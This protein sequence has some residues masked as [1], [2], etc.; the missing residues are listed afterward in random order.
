MRTWTKSY[1]H[2]LKKAAA[3]IPVCLFIGPAWRDIRDELLALAVSIWCL[4]FC[5]IVTVTYPISVF[6]VSAWACEADRRAA[7]RH[8]AR[9]R[10]ASRG[11]CINWSDEE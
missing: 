1:L 11:D 5:A 10:E 2:Y 6:V 4:L 7:K 3:S 8:A 9:L